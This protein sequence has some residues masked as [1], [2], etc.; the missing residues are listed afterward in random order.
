WDKWRWPGVCLPLARGSPWPQRA[1]RP[2]SCIWPRRSMRW[3]RCSRFVWSV[4]ASRPWRATGPVR[5][6]VS[7]WVWPP[8]ARPPCAAPAASWYAIL[9]AAAVGGGFLADVMAPRLPRGLREEALLVA[10]LIAAGVAAFLAFRFFELPVLA[11]FAAVVGMATELG[12]LA[13]QS[14]MQA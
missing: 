3:G 5:G 10:S 2:P 13:F 14:L 8:W 7:G 9:G 12:R 6:E 1:V 4:P 11:L